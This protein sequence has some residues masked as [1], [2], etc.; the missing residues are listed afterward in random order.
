MIR[1]CLVGCGGKFDFV[2]SMDDVIFDDL[3]ID[4]IVV[5]YSIIVIGIEVFF[6]M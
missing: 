4:I 5:V 6:Y 2:V 1:K 3:C